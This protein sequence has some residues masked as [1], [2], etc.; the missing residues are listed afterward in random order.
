MKRV[1]T[2]QDVPVCGEVRVPVG[3]I[4][5]SSAREVAAARGVRIL[6]VPED[7]LSARSPRRTTVAIGSDHGGFRSQG[8][9]QA[10]PRK[11]RDSSRATSASA[12][13]S[14]PTIPIS[15]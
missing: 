1:I 11:P 13:R 14:P 3:T 15:P 8:S 9:P 4:V 12:K 5:T 10:A 7:Q 6:E 2:A